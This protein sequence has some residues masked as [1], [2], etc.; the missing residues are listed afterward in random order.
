LNNIDGNFFIPHIVNP[1]MKRCIESTPHNLYKNSLFSKLIV[2]IISQI[3]HQPV[4]ILIT[5]HFPNSS[6][7]PSCLRDF[8]TRIHHHKIPYR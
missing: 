8:S 2:C 3:R 1:S 4:P 6:P 7:N 5:Q